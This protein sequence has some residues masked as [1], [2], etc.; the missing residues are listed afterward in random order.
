MGLLKLIQSG[1]LSFQVC[2]IFANLEESS[3]VTKTS[4]EKRSASSTIMVFGEWLLPPFGVEPVQ[5]KVVYKVS[6]ASTDPSDNSLDV[7][8]QVYKKVTN[9]VIERC[10]SPHVMLM[11][12]SA[13][14]ENFMDQLSD[15]YNHYRGNLPP[16]LSNFISE[17]LNLVESRKGHKYDFNRLNVLVLEQGQGAS[18]SDWMKLNHSFDD[19]V[20]V[21]FQ[22]FYTLAVFNEIG[23]QQNDLHVGNVWVD[24]LRTPRWFTYSISADRHVRIYTRWMVKI[25]DFDRATKYP[26]PYNRVSIVNTYIAR[27]SSLCYA[28]G[29]CNAPPKQPK[30]DSARF[31]SG[32][33]FLVKRM[34]RCERSS[35]T[36]PVVF[37]KVQRFIEAIVPEKTILQKDPWVWSAGGNMIC[38]KKPSKDTCA[39]FRPT[40]QQM[41]SN[42]Q[43]VEFMW[44][45]LEVQWSDVEKENRLG[46][47][48]Y[49]YPSV[50]N[51]LTSVA[52]LG[53][54]KSKSYRGAPSKEWTPTA[55]SL[56]RSWKLQ[57]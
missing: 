25:Y 37:S 48:Y 20:K 52:S 1:K 43:I 40:D 30:V 56:L 36:S 47:P 10:W 27:D 39:I 29:Q 18:F 8:S 55:R 14:C 35:K 3:I 17:Q 2:D 9:T 22:V 6:F 24:N 46:V 16:Y 57:L 15:Y 45:G 5:D 50:R 49:H 38:L 13:S 51:K 54:T 41:M 44:P 11:I 21:F 53:S 19:Y 34:I 32:V 23:L 4:A 28:Y 26:T 7:E 33:Y 42:K 31:I 12:A